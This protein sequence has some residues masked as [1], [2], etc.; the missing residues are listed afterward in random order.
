MEEVC[1]GRDLNLKW[2]SKG[3]TQLIVCVCNA[4][5]HIKLWLL[6][7]HVEWRICNYRYCVL[8]FEP[9]CAVHYIIIMLH[10]KACVCMSVLF[11]SIKCDCVYVLSQ[12]LHYKDQRLRVCAGKTTSHLPSIIYTLF[13][14]KLSYSIYMYVHTCM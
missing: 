3:E 5:S 13:N 7:I 2:L 8:T 6:C 14:W 9:T 12:Q 4:Y 1:S 11:A 10:I